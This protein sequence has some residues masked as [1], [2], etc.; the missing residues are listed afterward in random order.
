MTDG[1][2][3]DDVFAGD[4]WATAPIPAEASL[5]EAGRLDPTDDVPVAGAD[6]A[7]VPESS[8]PDDPFDSPWLAEPGAFYVGDASIDVDGEWA[9]VIEEIEYAEEADPFA[10]PDDVIPTLDP[11]ADSQDPLPDADDPSW[12]AWSTDPA[13]V[14]HPDE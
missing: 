5:P 8:L 3:P 6:W 7:T 2:R 1:P 11:L 14:E 4:D 10:M 9:E 13:V 12:D